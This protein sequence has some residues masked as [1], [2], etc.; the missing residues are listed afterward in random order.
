MFFFVPESN[1]GNGQTFFRKKEPSPSRKDANHISKLRRDG[2]LLIS[3]SLTAVISLLW[4]A[5]VRIREGP[6]ANGDTFVKTSNEYLSLQCLQ[7]TVALT[8]YWHRHH[9][10][11]RLAS[12]AHNREKSLKKCKA[13]IKHQQ[14]SANALTRTR[15]AFDRREPRQVAGSEKQVII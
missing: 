11:M 12:N 5:S 1:A 9:S 2:S 4:R 8:L 13:F 10:T 15:S 6:H 3:S 7:R 14:K